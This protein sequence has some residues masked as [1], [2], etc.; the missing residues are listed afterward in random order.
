M[1]RKER[2]SIWLTGILVVLGVGLCAAPAGADE[3]M[4]TFDRLPLQQIQD[5]Y[6][7]TP[8]PQWIEHV[9]RSCVRV[10]GASGAFVSAD[11]LVLT[12]HHVA[13][14]QIQKLSTPGRNLVRDGFCART[15][16]EEL[17]CTDLELRVLA[18]TE[19]VTA[20][21]LAAVD[22]KAPEERQSAQRRAVITRLEEKSTKATGLKSEVV[23]LYR[24][25]EYWLYRYERYT[26]ARLVMAPESEIA[27][28][29]GDLDNFTY[30]R[31]D[32]DIS[33]FRIYRDGKPLHSPDYLRWSRTG[34][35]EN[36][37]IFTA[38]NPRETERLKTVAQIEYE[39]DYDLPSQ[40]ERL[41]RRARAYYDY[42]ERG[43]EQA[44]QTATATK[45]LENGLKRLRGSREVLN[46]PA[47][48]EAR[49]AREA[50]LRARVA[51]NPALAASCGGAWDRIA[52]AQQE[53]IRRHPQII[54]RDIARVSRL[55]DIASGI[56]RY[57]EEVEKPNERRLDEFRAANLENQRF[58]LFS[59][60]PI[61]PEM[62]EMILAFALQEM[63]DALGP[64]DAFVKAALEGRPAAEVAHRLVAGTALA[65]I[66]ARRNLIAGGRK[67]VE[68][69]ADPMIQWARRIDAPY[70]ELRAWRE[71]RIDNVESTEGNRIARA[72][73]TL[74][75]GSMYSDATGTLRLSFGKA[76][77]Y[78][79]G[80]TLVPWKTTFYGLYDRAES[81]GY[82]DPFGLP[83]RFREH[84]A[85]LDL[86]TPLN[87][88]TTNDIVGGSSGS[89]MF[90]REA[91]CVGVVFDGN[92]PGFALDYV[93]TDE[94]ARAVAVH[95]A[96]I[97]ET[98]RKLYGMGALADELE[99]G[100]AR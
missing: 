52:A 37:L 91:E 16:D 42:A 74:E 25:G 76:A 31:H 22:P 39:R 67:A 27:A 47:V 97:I 60:A 40:I 20:R 92:I 95:S 28:Y 18:S 34:P 15:R 64:D 9:R 70:R 7:F 4:W 68:A 86:A 17:P 83:A 19:D 72:L 59:K 29:G 77:G 82:R 96:A 84:R 48:L 44:R 58:R 65:G 1:N 5:R 79:L 61:F 53:L 36:E 80:T 13:F 88:V 71:T 35:A 14:D 55:A 54:H 41:E 6:G 10:G 2:T 87:F 38:G 63:S 32:L 89:P 90:N 93:Y 12:N 85:G 8:S 11:G 46:N 73:F 33:F 66:D 62:E 78:E 24:G 100:A 26:E 45:F 75:G 98:L 21:V 50:D 30:P 43:P 94:Q 56:V 69:S 23:E 49:R 51:A 57:V 3:G 81:F 99:G